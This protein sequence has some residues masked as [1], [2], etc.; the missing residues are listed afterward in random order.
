MIDSHLD[1]AANMCDSFA[2]LEEQFA[3]RVKNPDTQKD[4][5]SKALA[6]RH[7]AAAIRRI[8]ARRIEMLQKGA[9]PC[10]TST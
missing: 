1:V 7:A 4:S 10:P 6:Y 3:A 9:T 5:K 2:A 8:E